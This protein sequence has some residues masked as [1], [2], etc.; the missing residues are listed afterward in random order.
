MW[1]RASFAVALLAGVDAA[2]WAQTRSPAPPAGLAAVGP[3]GPLQIDS[4]RLEVRDREKRAIFSG[5]VVAKRGDMVMR[6]A[7][8]T[9]FYDQDGARPAQPAA[10]GAAGAA[11]EGQQVRRIEMAGAVF[12]C[13]RDQ[14]ARG[15]RAVYER[16]SE[17]PEL[18][19]QVVLPE[20]DSVISGP[21]LVVNMRTSLAQV[22]SDPSRPGERVRS[23]LV[24]NSERNAQAQAGAGGPCVPPSQAPPPAPAARPR[25]PAR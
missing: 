1:V 25:P 6:A 24:P 14:T 12:F 7:S 21:R 8:M 16:A 17:T 5:N 22:T 15:E 20:D 2:A 9:V 4:D 18:M 3:S 13:Q 11:P 10:A 23:I 19:G